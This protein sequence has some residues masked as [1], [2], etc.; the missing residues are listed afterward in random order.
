MNKKG[1]NVICGIAAALSL[2]A[3]CT[4]I[5]SA[6]VTRKCKRLVVSVNDACGV[7]D[8]ALS[9]RIYGMADPAV[10]RQIE[11]HSNNNEYDSGLWE[12]VEE[13]KTSWYDSEYQIRNFIGITLA[14]KAYVFYS[15]TCV[16]RKAADD[17]II[18]G[19]KDIPCVLELS[20]TATGWKVVRQHEPP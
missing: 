1:K 13:W 2:F 6:L 14:N 19:S 7:Y 18:F 10:I 5:S 16:T 11:F 4:V 8:E 3:V 20:L 12:S 15:Y 17:K 9:E